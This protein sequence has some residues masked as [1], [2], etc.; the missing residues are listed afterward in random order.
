MPSIIEVEVDVSGIKTME[1]HFIPS[2][3]PM[4]P[5]GGQK[6]DALANLQIAFDRREGELLTGDPA[7]PALTDD[8]AYQELRAQ[9]QE[10]LAQ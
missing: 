3:C 10:R 6:E 2:V 7:I 8:P 4:P 5:S 9:V 1:D